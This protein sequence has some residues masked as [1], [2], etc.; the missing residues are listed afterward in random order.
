MDNNDLIRRRD[1]ITTLTIMAD[2]MT[3]DGAIVMDR[4][5]DIMKDIPAVDAAEVRHSV[6]TMHR[7]WEHDGEP[8][9][10][11]CGYA[12]Y[13]YRDCGKFCGNCGARMDGQRSEDG[14]A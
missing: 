11:E 12:P 7:T 10:K 5:A 14:D 3:S 2:K 8:Y 1:A 4:A 13:D 9:C 6:W